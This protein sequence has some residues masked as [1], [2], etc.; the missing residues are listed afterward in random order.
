MTSSENA[1]DAGKERRRDAYWDA[2]KAGLIFLVILG[3][4]VQYV[5][6]HNGAECWTDPLFKGIYMFHL[7]LFMLVSGYFAGKSVMER[8]WQTLS[9]YAVRLLIPGFTFSLIFI[10][11]CLWKDGG[12]DRHLIFS[13]IRKLWFLKI[14]FCCVFCYTLAM[15]K[16]HYLWRSVFLLLPLAGCLFP[17]LRQSGKMFFYLWPFFLMGAALRH[18]GITSA[19]L[20]GYWFLFLP[21]SVMAYFLFL[22]GDY[23]YHTPL[24]P[25]IMS[26]RT[27]LLRTLYAMAGCGAFL[28][29]MRMGR[30]LGHLRAVQRVGRATLALYVLQAFLFEP[31]FVDWEKAGLK[32]GVPACVLLAL[33]ILIFCYLLYAVTGRSR[34]FS[35]LFYGE[36]GS[37]K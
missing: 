10:L 24:A 7:P 21:A 37:G 35:Q 14:L 16:K 13:S 17:E 8:G 26:I 11:F 19:S 3:H 15:W 27:T 5:V 33:A 22:P 28:V 2:V 31:A 30:H 18:G 4:V 29:L 20:S 9:R 6:H 36:R 23:V 32:P 12:L 34:L 1:E 25:D